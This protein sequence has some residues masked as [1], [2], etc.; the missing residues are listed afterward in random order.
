[1]AANIPSIES[2]VIAGRLSATGAAQALLRLY[3]EGGKISAE[4]YGK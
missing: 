1:V 4:V 2:D 3:S